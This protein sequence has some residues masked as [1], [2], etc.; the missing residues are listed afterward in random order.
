MQRQRISHGA[1]GLGCQRRTHFKG[2]LSAR[3]RGA[4][5]LGPDWVVTVLP[6]FPSTAPGLPV[7]ASVTEG[8]NAAGLMRALEPQVSAP[9]ITTS[10]GVDLRLHVPVPTTLTERCYLYPACRHHW[11]VKGPP[12][13]LYFPLRP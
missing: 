1:G 10:Q 4:R 12:L 13:R 11:A 7:Y 8:D 3:K 2:I 9:T 6:R 5:A